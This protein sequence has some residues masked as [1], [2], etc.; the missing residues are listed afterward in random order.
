MIKVDPAQAA[1]E[2]AQTHWQAQEWQ[3]T[4]QACAEALAV[5]QKLP[6][7]HKLMG[8]AL[9]KTGKIK[10]AVGYYLQAIAIKSDFAEVHVN[11]GSLY[12]NQKQWN[13]AIR[14]YQHALRIDP[15][16]VTV[17]QHLTRILQLRLKS[18]AN[19]E[20]TP[21]PPPTLEHYLHRGETAKQQG[22]LEIALE[23]YRQAAKIAPNNIDV[24]R[25]LASIS[26]QLNQWQDAASYCRTIW[27][28][29]N[30]DKALK[31]SQVKLPQLV[32][33]TEPDPSVENSAEY[34][35]NLG[36]LHGKQQQWNRAIY[37]YQQA[38]GEDPQMAKAYCDLARTMAQTG[39][40]E[41]SLKYWLEAIALESTGIS[42]AE[43]LELAQNLVEWKK[44]KLA[45]TCYHRAIERQPNLVAPYLGWGELL[46]R[47]GSSKQAIACYLEG[48]KHTPDSP[49]LFYRLGNLYQSLQKLS[50][51]AICYQKATQYQPDYP[52]AYHQ[53]GEIFSQQEQWSEAI[54]AYRQ[55]IK[56]SPDFSWSYNN[57]GYAL[58]Q[59]GQWADA[60]PVYEQAIALNPDFSWSYYNLAEAH[61]MLGQWSEAI[62][63]YQ[64]AAQI[65]PDLPQVQ[66]KLGEAFY[67]RSQQ[68]Q[69][70]ALEQ[71]KLAIAQDPTNTTAYH[72]ALNI[73]KNNLE[74]Y[75][76]LA[77]TLVQQE[78]LDEAVVVYQMAWQIQPKNSI[79]LARLQEI[80]QKKNPSETDL[81]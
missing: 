45:I 43:Y 44:Y 18:T 56:N 33:A 67:Q 51:A 59:V 70:Q 68:D 2:R 34:H 24:Y 38:I 29:S 39:D 69:P 60:I 1:L 49:E 26:E 7:A 71:F 76:E 31:S 20:Q 52:Q 66:Q 73:D 77:E 17:H 35:Y 28:L 36:I 64:Q 48:L 6:I 13:Q 25:Q 5:D 78:K 53:L 79:I 47:S 19:I 22:R 8:D 81:T 27:Q 65:Q 12:A 41:Q 11:L 16:L 54:E 62:E 72:Q 30:S 3:L 23:Q 37:H 58:V 15:E 74:L 63:H 4:I 14:C 46:T 50:Q 61:S 9:Q 40:R 42:A 32:P 75:Q 10:E 80:L 55:A 21:E 57:L